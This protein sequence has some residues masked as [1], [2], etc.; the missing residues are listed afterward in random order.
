[1]KGVAENGL[2]MTHAQIAAVLGCSKARIGQLERSALRKMR[3]AGAAHRE[4]ILGL[5]RMKEV[6]R[7][8]QRSYFSSEREELEI[9]A[10]R[11]SRFPVDVPA[12]AR[13]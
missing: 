5:L 3:K 1:M 2:A 9:L 10:S 11:L 6:R 12:K 4:E 8:L 7:L 13:K